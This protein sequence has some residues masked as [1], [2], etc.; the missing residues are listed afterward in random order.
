M[1]APQEALQQNT[2]RVLD[3]ITNAEALLGRQDID[4]P[5]IAVFGDEST[6]KSSLLEAICKIPFPRG[7]QTV[8]RCPTLL[9]MQRKPGAKWSA[10]VWAGY[11]SANKKNETSVR[12]REDVA[13]VIADLQKRVLR[14][15]SSFSTEPVTVSLASDDALDL[16]LVDLPGYFTHEGLDKTTSKGEVDRVKESLLTYLR[17]E[18]TIVLV[19]VPANQLVKTVN[20][21]NIL[22]EYEEDL[23]YSER[24]KLHARTIYCF[25]KVSDSAA[26]LNFSC[27]PFSR[28][29]QNSTFATP[30]SRSPPLLFLFN[31]PLINNSAI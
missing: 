29:C 19:V 11:E 1:R 28:F 27:T 12:R 5:R 20:I 31:L 18:N 7:G 10:S 6:G 17:D 2:G 13:T 9:R 24:V 21:F 15:D 16:I 26:I 8:T 3:A 30:E 4:F 23:P 14:D 22:K 25:T